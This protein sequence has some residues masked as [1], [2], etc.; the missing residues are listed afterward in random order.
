MNYDGSVYAQGKLTAG[1]GHSPIPPEPRSAPADS[2][3]TYTFTG[4]QGYTSG[5]TISGNVTFHRP[6]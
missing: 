6:V 1:T 4:W 2:Q 3:Y 5:M